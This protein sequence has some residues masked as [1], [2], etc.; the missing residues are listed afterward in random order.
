MT[1]YLLLL[2]LLFFISKPSI[3]QQRTDDF[4]K[5]ILLKAGN[6]S[7]N[8]LLRNPGEYRLQII[9]TEINRDKNNNPSFKNYYFNHDPDLYFNPASMVKLPLAFLALEKLNRLQKKGVNKHIPL[10]FDSNYVG[11]KPL[12]TDATSANGLPSIAHFIRRAFLVSENDPYNRLYQFVGQQEINRNLHR[13][14]YKDS[15]IV[16]Q[17]M[18]FT[19]EQNRHTNAVRFVND[20]GST[21]YSQ[22]PA[23]NSDSLDFNK[24]VLL[25]KAH[26]NSSDSLVN[27]PFDFTKQNN[28][29]LEDLQQLLQ[30]VMF[31]ASV[32]KKQRFNLS[33]DD[34]SF[35]YC[36]L[37]QYPSE[38]P[39]PKYE[40]TLF[41]DSYAK[42]FFRDSSQ[43]MP[44][45]IRVFNKVGWSYGF[46]TDVS[47]VVDFENKV[48]YMLAATLYVNSDGILNDGK[49]DYDSVGYPFLYN[50]GQIIYNYELSRAR[51]FKPD[52]SAFQVQYEKRNINDTRPSLKEVD[53]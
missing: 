1:R 39:Y 2:I 45:N 3:S 35:L 24:V 4:L 30:S 16:R 41:Y 52:L 33:E 11:Q 27:A 25:G 37:S 43:P 26:Y 49:Y 32:P 7:V 9:Y 36:Y 46:L 5:N 20:D 19:E 51:T 53:N 31:P 29:P 34:Y 22:P 10:V 18:G 14:G 28:L 42:F 47:Y 40:A 21:R 38:T 8:M 13:K 44:A 17:F 48:E 12:Y 15:R 23:Y 50:L 6:D